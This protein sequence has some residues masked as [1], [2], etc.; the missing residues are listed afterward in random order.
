[1]WTEYNILASFIM[2]SKNSIERSKQLLDSYLTN[3]TSCPDFFANRDP[4]D[5]AIVKHSKL[6]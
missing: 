3:R 6:V 4:C 5:P 2:G 1:M